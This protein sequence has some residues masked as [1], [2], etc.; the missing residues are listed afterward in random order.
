MLWATPIGLWS[1]SSL[2]GIACR[3][4]EDGRAEAVGG[5]GAGTAELG[6]SGQCAECGLYPG[7]CSRSKAEGGGSGESGALVAAPRV[8]ALGAQ[9]ESGQADSM[10]DLRPQVV[11]DCQCVTFGQGCVPPAA[12]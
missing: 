3:V 1:R 7:G 11:V 10:V 8:H 5:L 2:I 12:P 4:R 6:E 9:V